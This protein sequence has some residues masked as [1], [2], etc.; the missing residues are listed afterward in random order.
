M[1]DAQPSK[2]VQ[3]ERTPISTRVRQAS[4]LSPNVVRL[5]LS[6]AGLR[7]FPVGDFTDHY[8]KLLFPPDGADY[9]MPFDTEQVREQRPKVQW[10]CTRTFTVRDHDAELGELTIDFVVHGTTGIAGPWAAQA[11][12]GDEIQLLGPGGGYAPDA[13]ADWYL[14]VGDASA[15]PAIAVSLAQVPAGKQALV[16]V[17]VDDLR[18]RQELP[19]AADADVRWAHRVDGARGLLDAV[20]ALDFPNGAVDAFVHG[21]AGAV[22]AVRRHLLAERGVP[23]E[24]LSASGYWKR[25]RTDEGWR[26]EKPEWKRQVALDAG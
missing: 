12:P 5:V 2:P 26:A 3:R 7:G 18:D 10:P 23:R 16:L 17:E 11:A 19:T 24:A 4:R 15:L 20:Q 22:R 6:G 1:T 9:G 8:V 14:F 13:A 21:E 25:G